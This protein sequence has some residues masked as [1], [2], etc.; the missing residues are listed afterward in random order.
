MKLGELTLNVISDGRLRLDGGALFGAVPKLL[1][2]RKLKP[3]RRNRVV[4]GLNCLLIRSPQRTVL[5]DTGVGI[6][7]SDA[8]KERYGFTSSHLIRSLRACGVTPRE[9]DTVVLTHLHF[10]HAGGSTKYDRSGNPV[11]TFPRAKYLIQRACW[12]EANAPNERNRASYRPEDFLPLMERAQVQ[13]LDGD[14]EIMP[15]V[16]ARPTGGHSL[17][18]Q[19]VTIEG[20]SERIAFLGDLVPTN[21]HLGLPYIAAFD[22]A[23][24]ETLEQKRR[25]LALIEREG[26][27]MVFSHDDTYK[28][29]YLDQRNGKLLF[30]AVEL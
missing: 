6:K 16:W 13:L 5:V 15:H 24:N 3:D 26:W 27:L 1:W 19:I 29:G 21:Y 11:A 9:V 17:G 14:A 8:L 4:L 30:R 28:A 7:L 10:D 22:D 2:E 25:L 23:P 12:E 20:R 18:H